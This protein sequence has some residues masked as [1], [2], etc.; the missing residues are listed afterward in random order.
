MSRELETQGFRYSGPYHVSGTP[1]ALDFNRTFGGGK[2]ITRHG[3]RDEKLTEE[4][5][6]WFGSLPALDVGSSVASYSAHAGG[7]YTQLAIAA[8]LREV[9]APKRWEVVL[10]AARLCDSL[11]GALVNASAA[12]LDCE[13]QMGALSRSGSEKQFRVVIEEVRE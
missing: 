12:L 8:W 4:L 13:R 2:Y 3:V 9:W 10:P 5:M 1:F 11:S 7:G 6:R